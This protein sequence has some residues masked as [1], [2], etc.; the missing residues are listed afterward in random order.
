MPSKDSH[1]TTNQAA[2]TTRRLWPYI[3]RHKGLASVSLVSVILFAATGR[4]IPLVFGFAIDKGITQKNLNL[5]YYAAGAYLILELSRSGFAFCKDYFIAR[6]GNRVL[7]QVREDLIRHVQNLPARFFDQTPVGRI[8]TRVTNDV[9]SLQD[10]FHDGVNSMF[11]MSLELLTILVALAYISLPLT[12]II[13]LTLPPALWMSLKISRQLRADFREAKS[14][15]S[16]INAFTAESLNGMKILQLYNRAPHTREKFAGYSE[17]YRALQMKTV[18]GFAKLWPILSYFDALTVA[19]SLFFGAIF[20][21]RSQITIGELSAFLLLAQ[22][23]FKPVR[24]ILERFNQFQN[25]LASADRIFALI[26]EPEEI[27]EGQRFATT[28]LKGEVEFKNLTFKYDKESRPVLKNINLKIAPGESVALVGRTGSGKST[29][30]SLLQKLYNFEDGDILVDGQSLSK[31]STQELRQRIGVVRQDHFLIRGTIRDNISLYNEEISNDAIFEAALKANCDDL[32]QRSGH[33]LDT[34]VEER[35][36][37]LSVGEK[38]LISFARVLAY[39]PDI[40]ILDE[41]TAN[42]DSHSEQLIQEATIEATKGR[43]SIIIAH[44][45]S[46]ILHCD[47]IVVLH[48]GEIVEMGSHQK[49]METKGKYW[50]YQNQ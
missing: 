21:T 35:G 29:M 30:V 9:V 28:P 14:K 45:L 7:F 47:R 8:I 41:A 20:F 17:E 12:L 1:H 10:F 42:I 38:Q 16:T 44:R 46:T 26:D 31:L 25:S 49:L 27:L 40:L 3:K 13:I 23:F 19:L 22:S 5:V 36:A 6:L 39:N 34:L 2:G 4:A 15:L 33:G 11:V 32:I 48:D 24:A 50:E 43:T 37:N 18:R